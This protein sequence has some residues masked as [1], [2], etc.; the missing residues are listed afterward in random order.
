MARR[1]SF[2]KKVGD[3]ICLRLAQGESLREI[4]V[5]ERMPDKSTVLRWILSDNKLYKDFREKYAR[6]REI[7]L[8]LNEDEIL[9]IADDGSN[10]WM[11][12]ETERG[13]I[14]RTLDHEHV[15]RSKLRIE[16]RERKIQRIRGGGSNKGK[17]LGP[18]GKPLEQKPQTVILEIMPKPLEP[19]K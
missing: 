16:S 13:K 8:E 2:T 10:D 18:N 14:I 1:T 3:E 4:C 5:D 12:R 9:D 17:Q 19:K 15:Q 11:D 7:Q 6:A